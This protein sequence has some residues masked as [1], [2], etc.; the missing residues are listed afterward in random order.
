MCVPKQH[1]LVLPVCGLHVNERGSAL[2]C[3]VSVDSHFVYKIRL[4]LLAARLHFFSFH[5]MNTLQFAYQFC[6]RW[7][8]RMCGGFGYGTQHCYTG[9]DTC[10]LVID[11]SFFRIR[12]YRYLQLK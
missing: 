10:A 7:S 9:S 12:G 6:C 4:L 3:S 11:L 8:F 5:S 1:S 2:L